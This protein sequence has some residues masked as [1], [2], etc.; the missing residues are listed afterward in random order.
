[1]IYHITTRESWETATRT[2]AYEAASLATQGFIHCS[3][4]DQVLRIADNLFRGQS[5]LV[6]LAVDDN[7]LP[8]EVRWEN[9]EGGSEPFPHVYGPIPVASVVSVADLPTRQDGSFA[10]PDAWK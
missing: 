10:W 1:M 4:R 3:S 6:L 7:D 2:G 5:G 9:L 8:A